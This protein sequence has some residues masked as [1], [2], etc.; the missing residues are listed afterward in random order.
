[1]MPDKK[2]VLVTGGNGGIGRHVVA[3]L[4]A[5]GARVTVADLDGTGCPTDATFVP[6]DLSTPD[7]VYRLGELFRASPP[8]ILVNLAGVNVFGAFEAIERSRLQMLMQVNLLAPMQLV[9]SLLP[10]MISRGSG[11][12]VNISSVLGD[13]GLP[14]FAAYATSKAGIGNFSESLRRELAGRGITVTLIAPRAVK[15]SMNHGTIEQFNRVSGANED[16]PE[17]VADIIVG[18]I[19]K[20]R[21]RITIGFPERIF[22]KVNA[23]LPSVVDYS[24]DRNRRLAEDVLAA[25]SL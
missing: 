11:Q 2:Q 12:I 17:R 24:L 10:S 3:R 23:L 22:I 16:S 1:M 15:T 6:T 20:D 7:S 13:I 25:D 14:Y 18:A 9:H 21:K 19:S 4:L 5:A 8:D